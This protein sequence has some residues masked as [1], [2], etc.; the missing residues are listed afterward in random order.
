MTDRTTPAIADIDRCIATIENSTKRWSGNADY[1]RFLETELFCL[2]EVRKRLNCCQQTRDQIAA[3]R[4]KRLAEVI[5]EREAIGRAI[6]GDGWKCCA[7]LAPYVHSTVNELTKAL[8]IIEALRGTLERCRVVL[9]NMALE[10]EGAII[11]RWPINHEPLRA[12]ARGLLPVIDEA[13]SQAE[14]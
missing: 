14:I 3:V 7:N 11:C 2:R 5:A 12:D 10:N 4:E 9:G 6:F 13:L 1:R 8:A